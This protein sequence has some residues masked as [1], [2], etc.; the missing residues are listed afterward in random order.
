[1]LIL[2][3]ISIGSSF[4]S[5]QVKQIGFLV[6]IASAMW[7]SGNLPQVFRHCWAYLNGSLF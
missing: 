5:S 6:R 4:G 1:M 7:N 3:G 2:K